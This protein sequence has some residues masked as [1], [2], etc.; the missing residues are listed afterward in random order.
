MGLAAVEPDLAAVGT[1]EAGEDLHQGG[2]AGAVLAE[3]PLDR[4]GR[5]RQADAVVGVHR[6]EGL[7]DLAKF[8][9]HGKG[10]EGEVAFPLVGL[11]SYSETL[12]P[13]IPCKSW[14]R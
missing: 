5:D 6:P 7:V 9:A 14:G 10:D 12:W 3:D 2:L 11:L 4:S 13:S 8:D 1:L